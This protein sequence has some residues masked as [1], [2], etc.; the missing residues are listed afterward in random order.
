G[1]TLTA[2]LRRLTGN[3]DS[4]QL[5]DN[6]GFFLV[7]G[8]SGSNARSIANF[9]DFP[10]AGDYYIAIRNSF[11]E[12]DYEL[13]IDRLDTPNPLFLFGH[14]IYRIDAHAGDTLDLR[15]VTPGDGPHLPQNVLDARIELLN[16]QGDI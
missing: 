16:A 6:Q 4:I 12:N 3:I 14:D 5:Y 10:Y 8:G 1:D 7:S 11:G 15:T 13:T 2:T 9:N